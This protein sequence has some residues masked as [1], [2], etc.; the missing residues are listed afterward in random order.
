M[1]RNQIWD[2]NVRKEKK[3]Q[4]IETDKKAN[5]R[6]TYVPGRKETKEGKKIEASSQYQMK[7][8]IA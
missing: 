6:H 5:K 4:K 1:K 3:E 2:R 8:A 7:L